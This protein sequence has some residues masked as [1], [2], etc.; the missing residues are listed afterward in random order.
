MKIEVELD[1]RT[2]WRLAGVA[3][4]SGEKVA[5]LLAGAAVDLTDGSRDGLQRFT[6]TQ[7]RAM[8]ALFDLHWSDGD[9]G[10]ALGFARTTII[11]RRRLL[12]LVRGRM[13]R[14][15]QERAG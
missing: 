13:S 5:D 12:G 11:H 6:A 15:E 14:L 9:I 3:E 1:G 10:A 2:F 4:K 8:C 7:E